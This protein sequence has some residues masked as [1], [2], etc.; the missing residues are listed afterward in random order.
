MFSSHLT[1][2]HETQGIP[3]AHLIYLIQVPAF[4]VHPGEWHFPPGDTC[5]QEDLWH[6][7]LPAQHLKLQS[8]VK[9]E[10]IRELLHT[11][12][13]ALSTLQQGELR[14]GSHFFTLA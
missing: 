1:S 14:V 4:S 13:L 11:S 9:V 10:T 8:P 12:I 7:T 6:P 2:A 5:N 3:F